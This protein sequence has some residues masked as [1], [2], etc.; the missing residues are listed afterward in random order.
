VTTLLETVRREFARHKKVCD[1]AMAQLDDRAFFAVP[2]P[3]GASAAAVVNS[4]ALMVKHLAGNLTSRWSDFLSS[5]GDKPNRDRDREFLI[6]PQ[7]TRDHLI[8]AWETGWSTLFATLESLK[9]ADLSKTVTIRGEAHLVEEALIRGQ[10]AYL[11]RFLNP[12][13]AWQTIPP[14]QSKTYRKPYLGK[15]ARDP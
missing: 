14:G 10:I 9:E 7:D 15:E 1:G 8:S 5:D 2:A 4:P 3:A 13:G 11:S 6:E 12:E